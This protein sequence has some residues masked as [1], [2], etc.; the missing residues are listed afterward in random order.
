ML[1]VTFFMEQQ[2]GHRT[3]YKNLRKFIESDAALASTW[4]E[5]TYEDDDNLWQKLPGIPDSISGSL[6]GRSQTRRGLKNHRADL[7]FFN[8]QVPAAL[9]GGKIRNQKYVLCMDITPVHYDKMSAHYG[10]APDRNPLV[11][12]YKLRV[13]KQLFANAAK[14]IS[15][16]NW[17][18]DSL[19]EDYAVDAGKIVVI[20]PGVDLELWRPSQR[21]RNEN[22]KLRILFIGGDFERKGGDHLL[23]AFHLLP[24]GAAELIVVTRSPIVGAEDILVYN[25][26]RPNSPELIALCQ[27][28]D[29]F[30]LPTQAEAFGIA[31]LEASAMGLP[32]IT[33]RVGGLPE[34][35]VDGETGYFFQLGDYETLHELI[36]RMLV[37]R[38]LQQRL[39][40]QA[41]ERAEL[42][43]NAQTN[44]RKIADVLCATAG[45]GG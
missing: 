4:V 27:S 24:K 22:D 13:N 32:V 23:K 30:V 43:F 18:K 12:K 38:A 45:Q 44:A 16:S 36:H 35:V 7:Y 20:P 21:E 9:A 25:N 14:I 40:K 10:H 42:L 11:Q 17:T 39:G 2:V 28:C 41:R 34:V 33:T 37:D 3:F 5:I 1:N 26:M 29:V 31:A 15:W 6:V 8:T 19:I